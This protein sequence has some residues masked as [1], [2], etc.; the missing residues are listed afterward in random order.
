MPIKK[1]ETKN[2]HQIAFCAI[3]SALSVALMF[4]GSLF[5]YSTMLIAFF[6]GFLSAIVAI[7]TSSSKAF[8]AYFV[9]VFLAL[10]FV[11]RKTMVIHY[12]LF[13]GFYPILELKIKKIKSYI[14]QFMLK[15]TIM[16]I[17]SFIIMALTLF[18]AGLSNIQEN[19]LKLTSY[20]LFVI[21]CFCYDYFLQEF[22][23]FYINKI[24]NKFILTKL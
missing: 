2:I 11:A 9:V 22:K 17:C 20:L 16:C 23:A 15:L 6:C 10:F 19:N 18:I 13:G 7:E 5:F 8:C 21:S 12:A 1:N 24:K 4:L 14:L 3:M